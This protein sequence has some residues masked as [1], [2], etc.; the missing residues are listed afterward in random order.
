MTD[1]ATLFGRNDTANDTDT[2]T[3]DLNITE[4]DIAVINATDNIA[5]TILDQIKSAIAAAG[6]VDDTFTEAKVVGSVI[7]TL[8]RDFSRANPAE[9]GAFADFMRASLM[10]GRL[11]GVFDAVGGDVGER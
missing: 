1:L 11:Q 3:D 8:G 4:Q 2:T 7:V 9:A 5:G 10:I 6:I